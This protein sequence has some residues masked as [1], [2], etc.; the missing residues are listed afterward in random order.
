MMKQLPLLL[1]I[2]ALCSSYLTPQSVRGGDTV[3]NNAECSSAMWWTPYEYAIE[4]GPCFNLWEGTFEMIAPD[5]VAT[6]ILPWQDFGEAF[7]GWKKWM[8]EPMILPLSVTGDYTIR[9]EGIGCVGYGWVNGSFQCINGTVIYERRV[10]MESWVEGGP[11]KLEKPTLPEISELTGSEVVVSWIGG[12]GDYRVVARKMKGKAI[13]SY[14]TTCSIT[15]DETGPGSCALQ[16]V[17]PGRWRIR[18]TRSSDG[19]SASRTK[20][21]KFYAIQ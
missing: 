7:N 2:S 21:V 3:I 15:V 13:T 5:G 12:P 8:Q 19:Q 18:V 11:R 9:G 16:D 17:T 4:V 6:T 14:K 20:I 10:Y 1:I